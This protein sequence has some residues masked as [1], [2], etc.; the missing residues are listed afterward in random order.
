MVRH[1]DR[2]L[3]VS[4]ETFGR[5]NKN[6]NTLKSSATTLLPTGRSTRSKSLTLFVTTLLLAMLAGSVA[7]HAQAAPLVVT[8]MNAG[9]FYGDPNP[10]FAASIT[11]L[12]SGDAITVTFT[13]VANPTS[14]VGDYQIVPTLVDPDN[15]LSGYT[16]VINNGTLTV[17]PAPLSIVADDVTR[18]AGQPNPAFTGT[19]SGLKNG[20]VITASHDSPATV[21]SEAG[22][23]PIVPTLTVASGAIS[24]YSVSISN[25]T[26]TVTP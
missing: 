10:E 24:N 5:T 19:I 25:G 4:S 8:A 23:Y 20:E 17:T 16:V 21:D 7:A 11:G 2:V 3:F 12:R 9:R 22:T 6:M 1:E 18:A 13:T 14:A 15:K 26:L